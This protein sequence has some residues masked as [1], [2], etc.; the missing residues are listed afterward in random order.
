MTQ[1][2]AARPT[3]ESSAHFYSRDRLPFYQVPYA[4]ASKGMRAPTLADARKVAAIPSV[5]TYLQI[6]DKP[7]LNTWKVEQ[8][9][10][11]V[12]TS[13]RGVEEELDAFIHRVIQIER[14]H[15]QESEIARDKGNEIHAAMEAL[16]RNEPE[17]EWTPFARPAFEHVWKTVGFVRDLH[18]E[19]ILTSERHAGKVDFI[20]ET[21]EGNWIIDWKSTGKLP[22]KESY[23]EHRL[24]LAAYAKSWSELGHGVI[25]T[26]N[27]YIS[28]K[29]EGKFAFFENPPWQEDWPAFEAVMKIWSW[30]H[31]GYDPVEAAKKLKEPEL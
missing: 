15:E 13:P 24:Q 11:A 23:P 26:A 18:L 29:E 6:L 17:S 21:P 9:V 14:V 31:R 22:T 1:P 7:A 19:I 16:F 10:N 8:G 28:T 5:T 4:D 27:C 12:M 30:M 2:T 3:Q 25:R 20:A